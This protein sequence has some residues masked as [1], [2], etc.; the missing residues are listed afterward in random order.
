MIHR[1][2]FLIFFIFGP[3]SPQCLDTF[4]SEPG[5]S[6][7]GRQF[8]GEKYL[9]CNLPP[10]VWLAPKECMK[11]PPQI[12]IDEQVYRALHLLNIINLL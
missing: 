9:Q 12:K 7:V 2:G 11:Y 4:F 1:V 8:W 3:F 10:V 6:F 5:N